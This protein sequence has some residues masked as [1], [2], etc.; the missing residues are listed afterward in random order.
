MNKK[1]KKDES[2]KVEECVKFNLQEKLSTMWGLGNV[3]AVW[4]HYE[5]LQ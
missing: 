1:N 4:V 2:T 3:E 5:K